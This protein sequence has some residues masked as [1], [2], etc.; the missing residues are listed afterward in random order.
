MSKY[1]LSPVNQLL[2]T[3]PIEEYQRLAPHLQELVLVSGQVLHEPYEEIKSVYFPITAMISLVSIMENGST[4]EIGLIGNEGMIGLPIFLGGEYT[5]SRAIV[6]M[7]GKSWKISSDI[8][9]RE[10]KEAGTLQKILLLHTQA[11]LTQI[12]QSAA[13]NRQ[14]KIEARL[15]RWLLSVYDCVLKDELDLTQEFIS[16]ML[17]VRRAGVTIAANA[18]QDAGIIRY[19][20]GKIVILDHKKLEETSCECYRVVQ[21]EF[22]RLLG[23]RRG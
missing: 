16:N 3:L 10:F 20:R 13:C 7:S 22:L 23:S 5:I 19:N 15:A 12:A 6:Q 4:T 9:L 18:L 14:H 2:R 8:V 1:K 21:K 17:G 11:R